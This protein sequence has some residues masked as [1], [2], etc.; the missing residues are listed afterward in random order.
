MAVAYTRAYSGRRTLKAS[1]RRV[2]AQLRT[3]GCDAQARAFADLVLRHGRPGINMSV[4]RCIDFLT[5]GSWLNMYEAIAFETGFHGR[6][7]VTA[8]RTRL[9]KGG[10]DWYT[11]RRYIERLLRL[12]RDT[13]YAAINLGG[14]GPYRRYG[15][16][17]VLLD[18]K[19]WRGRATCF[20]GDTLLTCFDLDGRQQLSADQILQRY[21]VIEDWQR[22]ALFRHVESLR[23]LRQQ[24]PGFD[25]QL[26]RTMVE[27]RTRRSRYIYTE[28]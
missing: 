24:A 22:L 23:L 10:I 13:H 21:A 20:A 3:E 5:S 26:L 6:A 9:R 19:Q 7:Y 4:G 1:I 12:G 11:R 8:V 15:D 18:L 14:S 16:C 27:E 28:L 2:K 25:P 17:C